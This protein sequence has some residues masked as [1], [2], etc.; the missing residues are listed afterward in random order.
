MA[1]F[2]FFRPSSTIAVFLITSLPLAAEWEVLPGIGQGRIQDVSFVDQNRGWM[3]VGDGLLRTSNRGRSW[4]SVALPD[5]LELSQLAGV[6]IKQRED[7][8]LF[9]W[10]LSASGHILHTPDGEGWSTQHRLP[11]ELKNQVS[12]LAVLDDRHAWISGAGFTW[13]TTNGGQKW[14]QVSP[15]DP[16]QLQG[17]RFKDDHLHALIH[18]RDAKNGIAIATGGYS[19]VLL[20]ETKDGGATW[21]R[22]GPPKNGKVSSTFQVFRSPDALHIHSGG[23]EIYAHGILPA[24]RAVMNSLL[25]RTT[26]PDGTKIVLNENRHFWMLSKDIVA[27]REKVN[28][29][30]TALH[31]SSN[32]GADWQCSYT[33]AALQS[34]HFLDEKNGWAAGPAGRVGRTTDG[35]LTWE[36][37]FLPSQTHFRHVVFHDRKIGWAGGSPTTKTA[38]PL[39][40]TTDG[41]STWKSLPAI[42]PGRPGPHDIPEAIR[43]LLFLDA[44][45][46]WAI[47]HGATPEP[48]NG[49]TSYGRIL[50]TIDGGESWQ[51]VY[52]A[53]GHFFRDLKHRDGRFWV[54]GSG[55]FTSTDGQGWERTEARGTLFGIA[56]PRADLTLAVGESG[57]LII[58]RND[59][60]RWEHRP[61]GLLQRTHLGGIHFAD[62][63]IGWIIGGSSID[64]LHEGLLTT[65]DGGRL[66]NVVDF[67]WPKNLAKH[68]RHYL[69]WIDLS[70]PD[71]DHAWLLGGSSS[72]SLLLRRK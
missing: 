36:H 43:G 54:A 72:R 9:G 69:R 2:P 57:T 27:A 49:Y 56:Q 4:H 59:S 63:K 34:I 28:T 1:S 13:R 52:N 64:G 7:G 67:T 14:R 33:S 12:C 41:G 60:P 37:R 24:E 46:G 29:Y 8:T 19:G 47:T 40:K 65:R 23:H 53:D 3:T 48:V 51:E 10:A 26:I 62:D 17:G 50:R 5:A 68:E 58:T 55:V 31:L 45:R 66:W 39:W 32:A 38:R 25:E 11:A 20:K 21:T 30:H 70:A 71:T 42:K 61:L 35:G 44:K 6:E 16:K 15:V 22:Q 18:F